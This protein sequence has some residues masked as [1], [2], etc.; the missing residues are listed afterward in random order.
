VQNSL[1]ANVLL[2]LSAPSSPSNLLFHSV[3]SF[4]LNWINGFCGFFEIPSS[5][6]CLLGLD[7]AADD[8]DAGRHA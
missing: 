5:P 8:H 2:L 6:C 7:A 1:T 4:D 3:P